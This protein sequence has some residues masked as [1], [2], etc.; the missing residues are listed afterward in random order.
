MP[1]L[2]AWNDAQSVS[3]YLAALFS[4]L[5]TV[6]AVFHVV[7]PPGITDQVGTVAGLLGVV[8]ALAVHVWTHRSAHAKV[9]AAQ[10][11][12]SSGTPSLP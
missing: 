2:P 6:L 8:I 7:V 11:T 12:Q 10:A 5:V 3:L 4:T 9:A 1:T